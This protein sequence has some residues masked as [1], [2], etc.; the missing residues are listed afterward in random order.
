MRRTKRQKVLTGLITTLAAAVAALLFLTDSADARV[1]QN[2]GGRF[3]LSFLQSETDIQKRENL[4][5]E[6]VLGWQ[7]QFT[8]NLLGRAMVRYFNVGVTQ[9]DGANNWRSDLQPSVEAYWRQREFSLIGLAHYRETRSNDR[10]TELVSEL[11]GAT[12]KSQLPGYPFVRARFEIEKRYNRVDRSDRDTRDQ[13]YEFETGY[14]SLSF[15]SRYSMRRHVTDDWSRDLRSSITH[16]SL[17]LQQIVKWAGNGIHTSVG[18]RG[19]YKVRTDENF[20]TSALPRRL[21]IFAALAARDQSPETGGLDT[22][23]A[24]A[25]GNLDNPTNPPINIGDGNTYWNIGADLGLGREV[26]LLY[27]YTDAPSE[28]GVRWEVFT[29]DDAIFWQSQGATQSFFSPGFSRY[30]IS[31]DAQTTRYIKV[32]NTGFNLS[33]SVNVTELQALILLDSSSKLSLDNFVHEADI[34]NSITLSEQVTSN[35]SAVLRTEP[36]NELDPGRE[37]A[38]FNSML[39][40]QPSKKFHHLVRGELALLDIENVASE[41]TRSVSGGYTAE[42]LPLKTLDLIASVYARLNYVKSLRSEEVYNGVL[43]ASAD[44]FPRLQ[45]VQEGGISRANLN[46]S[47]RQIDGWSYR[48]DMIGSLTEWLEG[49]GGVGYREVHSSDG[50]T[51]RKEYRLGFTY[52]ITD[53]MQLRGNINSIEEDRVQSLS[54]DFVFSWRLTPKVTTSANA[55]LLRFDEGDSTERYGAQ[56][57]YNLSRRTILTASVQ[58]NDLT[59]TG[60]E[61]TL[62]YRFGIRTGF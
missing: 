36:G 23:A 46:I 16:H 58:E 50:T 60:G 18:Y 30:E 35:V 1:S 59:G 2:L 54:Q 8:R 27:L 43:R 20:S 44:P 29:S 24:L 12:F 34:N 39:R 22:V 40:H 49:R 45:I 55:Y 31:F 32:V 26:N 62:S 52:S 15:S 56:V 14:T 41:V 10:S 57:E 28:N 11:A 17:Q 38:Y 9:S 13:A 47:A 51:I 25:D 61:S 48:V 21:P 33:D 7:N 53:N 6:Y 5:Q 4:D 42:Y 19:E 37:E 3:R